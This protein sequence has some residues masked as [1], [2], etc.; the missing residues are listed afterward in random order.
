M[1]RPPGVDKVLDLHPDFM[2]H[3]VS[4]QFW[5]LSLKKGFLL[6]TPLAG[7]RGAAAAAKARS[8]VTA[9]AALREGQFSTPERA[10]TQ[11]KADMVEESGQLEVESSTRVMQ[12]F[13]VFAREGGAAHA[14][15]SSSS[16]SQPFPPPAP[17][18]CR[19]SA[20]FTPPARRPRSP[21]P[22]FNHDAEHDVELD[23][24]SV[25]VCF[26]CEHIHMDIPKGTVRAFVN[27]FFFVPMSADV[28]LAS[29]VV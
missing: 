4:E 28:V 5:W 6:H 27:K 7:S 16:S 11:F 9:R 17:P 8:Q 18:P 12:P 25:L 10:R 20:P 24:E 15:S 3:A 21:S 26:K 23:P 22:S 2:K 1:Y 14:A 19:P 13:Q 29:F